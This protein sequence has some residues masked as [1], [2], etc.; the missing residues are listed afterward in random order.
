MDI[1]I[2]TPIYDVESHLKSF[3]S[4]ISKIQKGL[5]D[6]NAQKG[7]LCEVILINNNPE[8]GIKG[9][10][11]LNLDVPGLKIIQNR[12]NIG[13]GA[14]CNQGMRMV[15]GKYILILNPDVR[16][17]ARALQN[18]VKAMENNKNANIISCKLLNEDGSLQ[19]SCKRFPNL[20]A[21]LARRVRFPFA[22]IFKKQL[23]RYEM[24]DYD[25]KKPRKVD[26]VSGALMLMRKKYFFDERYFMYFE[27]ADLCRGV[28]KV[29]YYPTISLVH[30]AERQSARSFKL[31]LFHM[32][33]GV[34]YFYKFSGKKT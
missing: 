11:G 25:H 8:K 26:W 24:A 18:L 15:K 14:A 23:D 9:G 4:T 6:A 12:K 20:R 22:S 17:E 34:Y 31:L 3:I 16:I 30:K 13:F 7:M 5:R 33:S 28:G 32:I 21:M 1:S 2:I 27:D 19:N 29:Y 10:K